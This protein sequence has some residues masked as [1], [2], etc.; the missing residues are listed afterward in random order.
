[1]G[2][3]LGW[4]GGKDQLPGVLGRCVGRGH[5]DSAT[6]V[7]NHRLDPS[8]ALPF[9]HSEPLMTGGPLLGCPFPESRCGTSCV[10]RQGPPLPAPPGKMPGPRG[11]RRAP[12]PPQARSPGPQL[13]VSSWLASHHLA[14]PRAG[15]QPSREEWGEGE[16]PK[17]YSQKACPCP[18]RGRGVWGV[19]VLPE[20]RP[21]CKEAVDTIAMVGNP[22][23]MSV[24]TTGIFKR[25]RSIY[26]YKI[27]YT[28][29]R[30]DF[31]TF[32]SYLI[33]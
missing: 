18:G 5:G 20:P 33:L 27:I 25:E 10:A 23:W 21:V 19:W 24:R 17:G 28:F 12:S 4:K 14:S 2:A 9:W 22:H 11:G 26:I 29:Y 31:H 3:A 7:L 13:V 6:L 30:T 8:P 1:M 32:S 15:C 16:G